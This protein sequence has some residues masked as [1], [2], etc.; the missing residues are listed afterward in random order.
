M[1]GS[2]EDLE[3]YQEA[4]K[5]RKRI[6]K[7]AKLL[8]PEEKTGLAPQMRHAAV[9]LTNNIAEGEGRWNRQDAIRFHRIARGSLFELLD[10][11]NVCSDE[12]YAEE[13][14]LADLREHGYRV[15][16][17]LDGYIRYLNDRK[18]KDDAE[19]RAVKRQTHRVTDEPSN[20]VTA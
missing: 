1:P 11:I 20:Q 14:H 16:R 6:Y 3:V 19:R 8:P 15:R 18:C 13:R 4:R 2:F 9:S 5:F 17:L 7:L 12:H 10:D